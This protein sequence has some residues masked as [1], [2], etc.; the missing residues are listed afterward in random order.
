MNMVLGTAIFC[1]AGVV[2][3]VGRRSDGEERAA[4]VGEAGSVA[5]GVGE[6]SRAILCFH[7]LDG[8]IAVVVILLIVIW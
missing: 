1:I 3:V 5:S 7:R 8:S 6:R 4:R 2:C